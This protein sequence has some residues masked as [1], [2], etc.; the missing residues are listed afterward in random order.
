MLSFFNSVSFKNLADGEGG[1]V[2]IN[3]KTYS[4]QYSGKDRAERE[5]YRVRSSFEKKDSEKIIM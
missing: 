1:G 3:L 4:L 2:Q 5:H